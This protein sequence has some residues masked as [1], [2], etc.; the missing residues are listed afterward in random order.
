M[1]GEKKM[2]AG[3]RFIRVYDRL[4]DDYIEFQVHTVDKL[5][6]DG[7]KIR[8]LSNNIVEVDDDKI[9]TSG[10]DFQRTVM[11]LMEKTDF[12]KSFK[13]YNHFVVQFT[14]YPTNHSFGSI[15]PVIPVDDEFDDTVHLF[16]GGGRFT[17]EAKLAEN[18]GF[19][20]LE[21][22]KIEANHIVSYWFITGFDSLIA[23]FADKARW[24]NEPSL[25]EKINEWL[26]E[27][28]YDKT[29]EPL[30]DYLGGTTQVEWAIDNNI[31][32]LDYDRWQLVQKLLKHELKY[33]TAREIFNTLYEKE[34]IEI[35]DCDR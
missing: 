23:F 8:T 19:S 3:D 10:H 17:V 13:T 31:D 27:N 22:R 16:Y 2:K 14:V 35:F 12:H 29:N 6:K 25:L 26:G 21:E 7:K 15:V 4:K 9:I 18:T 28:G 1:Q 30:K 24:T 11:K 5:S 33:E 34:E 32:C 20:K